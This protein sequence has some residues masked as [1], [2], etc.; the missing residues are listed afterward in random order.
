MSSTLASSYRN[1]VQTD[2]SESVLFEGWGY[3][4]KPLLNEGIPKGAQIIKYKYSTCW[5]SGLIQA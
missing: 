2:P 5:R 4:I 3:D 1:I